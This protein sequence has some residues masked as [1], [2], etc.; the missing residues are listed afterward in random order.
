MLHLHNT[1]G[2][3]DMSAGRQ[4]IAFAKVSR[5]PKRAGMLVR[6]KSAGALRLACLMLAGLGL[7][8]VLV[9][10][11]AAAQSGFDRV[12]GDYLKFEIR[13]GDPA[14]CAAYARDAAFVI[15]A[16]RRR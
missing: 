6:I 12:G 3:K 14:V 11:R 15:V 2:C 13:T 4:F 10:G 9:P 16:R 7:A 1:D 5:K 8:L